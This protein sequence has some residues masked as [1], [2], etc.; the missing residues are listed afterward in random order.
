MS[1]PEPL[2]LLQPPLISFGVGSVQPVAKRLV[3][4]GTR[5]VFLI[6]SRS[7]ANHSEPL[8]AALQAAGIQ[9]KVVTSVPPEPTVPDFTAILQLAQAF[10]PDAVV[11]FGGGSVLDVAK[12]VAALHDRTE[13]IR[14]LFGIGLLPGRN[15]YLVCVPTTSGTGSEVS[16]NAILLDETEKLK[17]AV[18]SPWLV[19]DAAFIDPAFTLTVPPAVTAATGI[20]AL[21]HCIEGYANRFAHPL[22]DVYALQGIRLIAAHLLRAVRNSGDLAARTAMAQGSLYGGLCLGP[23]NTAAVHALA[24]PLG[25]EFHLAHGLSNALLLVPVLR[26][27]LPSAPRRYADIALALGVTPA[28]DDLAT[29]ERGL[30]QLHS[31]IEE[32]GLPRGLSACGLSADTIPH[33]ASAAMKVTRLLKNNLREVTT[34]DAVSIYREAFSL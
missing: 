6:A 19:P 1:T 4:R 26:F 21:V 29:A 32:C 27:N 2:V 22:V 20:D 30:A 33:L 3:D 13:S 14:A 15:T 16:P 34:N 10:S 23:V 28:A 9:L 8:I 11:G 5:R 7:A 25:S 31:L 17:K 12:L 18:I 24:Y